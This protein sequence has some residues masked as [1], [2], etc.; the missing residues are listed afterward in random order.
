VFALGSGERFEAT[1][2][3]CFTFVEAPEEPEAGASYLP[4]DFTTCR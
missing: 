1:T 3:D 4:I 2:G